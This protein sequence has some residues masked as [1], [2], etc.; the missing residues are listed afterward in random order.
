MNNRSY[1]GESPPC[2]I[3]LNCQQNSFHLIQILTFGATIW[4]HLFRFFRIPTQKAR[5]DLDSGIYATVGPLG[6]YGGDSVA[7][8]SPKRIQNKKFDTLVFP[9]RGYTICS[10]DPSKVLKLTLCDYTMRTV[11]KKPTVCLLYTFYYLV[12]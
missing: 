3:L 1:W 6:L 7:A 5:I 8:G 4:P 10:R 11:A 12:K 2:L 9:L